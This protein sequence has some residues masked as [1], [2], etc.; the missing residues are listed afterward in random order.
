MSSSSKQFALNA[1]G[2]KKLNFFRSLQAELKKVTWTTK[3]ELLFSTKI[4]VAA[5]FI[6]GIVIYL[7]DL[8]VRGGLGFISLITRFIFG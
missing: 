1:K 2:K 7:I 4:V 3:S 8:F 6:L 5:T